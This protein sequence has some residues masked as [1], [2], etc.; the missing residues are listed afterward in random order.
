MT[1][2][3]MQKHYRSTLYKHAHINTCMHTVLLVSSKT[4]EELGTHAG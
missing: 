1:Q 3:A 4:G 2:L